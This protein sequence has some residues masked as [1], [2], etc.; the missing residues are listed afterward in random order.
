MLLFKYLSTRTP[1]LNMFH[2]S[3]TCGYGNQTFTWY[4]KGKYIKYFMLSFPV[5]LI[6]CMLTFDLLMLPM[7]LRTTMYSLHVCFQKNVCKLMMDVVHIP[8]RNLPSRGCT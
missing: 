3:G 5:G 6:Y 8:N 4:E 2:K 7:H 1:I